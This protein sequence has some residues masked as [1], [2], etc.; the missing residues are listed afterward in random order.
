M[1]RYWR[2]L[3]PAG[4]AVVLI[5]VLISNLNDNLV[6]FNPPT[7]PMERDASA[8]RL[9]L[10]GQ[11]VQ[12]TVLP[13][14]GGVEF[15]VTDGRVAVLVEHTGAP[16]ELFQEGIGVVV[17]GEWNG[18]SFRSDTMLVKHDENYSPED[19]DEPFSES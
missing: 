15:E 14:D 9:R 8:A 17:E 4:L 11:V 18:T 5:G 10:G 13:T 19:A 16:P 3:I 1:R 2:F 12:G 6:Y 7:E